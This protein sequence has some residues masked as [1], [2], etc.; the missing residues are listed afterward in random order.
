M[1]SLSHVMADVLLS[2]YRRAELP[3]ETNNSHSFQSLQQQGLI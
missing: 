1:K 2:I 3:A